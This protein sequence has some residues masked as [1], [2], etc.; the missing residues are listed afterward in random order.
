MNEHERAEVERIASDSESGA[1]ELVHRAA[2]LLLSS[3]QR[4][5]GNVQEVAAACVSAQPSMAGMLTLEAVVSNNSDPAP[6]IERFA[7]QVRRAPEAIA[8]HA[9]PLLRLGAAT[10][11]AGRAALTVVT[12]S[13]SAAVKATLRALATAADVRVRCAESRPGLEG[14]ALAR[15]LAAGPIAVE[16]FTDAGI[17][18]ALSGA[19]ALLV[20]ADA[21]GDIGF[22]NKVGT[23]ALCALAAHGGVPVYVLAGREKRL[24]PSLFGRVAMKSGPGSGIL[25]SGS[26]DLAAL[27]V[28]LRNPYFELIPLSLVTYLILDTGDMSL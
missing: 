13:G 21:V 6:A 5:G 2:M 16:L 1:S 11:R 25:L 14:A 12:C 22:V 24:S 28:T 20:G 23:A 7:M 3:A 17:S 4:P 27:P 15:E 18:S 8:A 19:D 26:L 9:V 10:N